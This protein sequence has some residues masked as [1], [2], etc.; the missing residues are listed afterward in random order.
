LHAYR[1]ITETGEVR[2]FRSNDPAVADGDQRRDFVFVRDCIDHMLWLWAH[3]DASGIYNSGTGTARTFLDLAKAVF[4]ALGR[5]PEIQFID[6]PANLIGQYQSFTQ[7]D[8]TKL[9][10]AGY[11]GPPTT[12]ESGA[13]ATVEWLVDRDR[14]GPR[15]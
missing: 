10:E 8:M 9:C 2:L 4:A 1:Q 11:V 13:L 6:M 12:L 14:T 5:E 15:S 7:A 3:P